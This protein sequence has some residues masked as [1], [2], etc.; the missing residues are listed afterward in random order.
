[1]SGEP[2]R[3]LATRGG[4]TESVHLVHGVVVGRS[5]GEELRF[6]DP[7]L[8]AFW[9]SSFKPFQALPLVEDGVDRA[10]GLGSRELALCA[11][12]H[13]GTPVHVRLAASILERAGLSEAD[14]ECGAHPPYDE[15]AA[16]DVLRRGETYGPLHNNCSGKHAG[17]LSLA[18]HH[19]W[20][21]HGYIE[22]DHPVQVRIRSGSAPFLDVDP[23][24]LAWGRDGCGVP[25][26][27]LSLRQMA[28][29]Y[30]RLGRKAAEG[31]PAPAAIVGAMTAHPEL[32]SGPGRSTTR[33]MEATGGRLLAKEGAEGVYCA[34]APSEG[35]GLALKVADGAARVAA[36]A[37]VGMLGEA[38]LLARDELRRLEPFPDPP[39]LNVAGV[40]VG[41]FLVELEGAHH[42]VT[43]GP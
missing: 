43:G 27:Y 4:E 29:A 40:E 25:T 14:L 37:M 38:G 41:R 3:V 15:E 16:R 18:V 42:A 10:L 9:R 19:G 39:I 2:G 11:S 1:M 23:E 17:M 20:E 8:L 36:A 13:A 28:R 30:A 33:L 5:P 12:S 26:A 7:S 35:W 24:A 31:D 32:V 6:G 21:T 34:A 22:Y